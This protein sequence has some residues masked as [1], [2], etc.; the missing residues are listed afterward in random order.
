MDLIGNKTLIFLFTMA[1]AVIL[2]GAA[3][4]ASNV[5]LC[6]NLSTVSSHTATNTVSSTSVYPKL[7]D[8][9]VTLTKSYLVKTDSWGRYSRYGTGQAYSGMKYPTKYY[10][11][12]YLYSSGTIIVYTHFYH[13]T[14]KQNMNQRIIIG[15]KSIFGSP[16]LLYMLITPKSWGNSSHQ[17]VYST[18][19]TPIQFYWHPTYNQHS[20]RYYMI[21]Y[22]VMD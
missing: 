14:L 19:G 22:P 9:G 1:F 7:I 13:T 16:K 10:W 3:S 4:A 21:K 6:K 20:L 12:T 5:P 8:Q 17:T 11:K 15:K 18:W 2:C